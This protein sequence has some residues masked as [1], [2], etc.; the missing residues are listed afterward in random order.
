M[1]T[2][3]DIARWQWPGATVVASTFD[4]WWAAFQDAVPLLPV[5]TL[6][7]GETWIIGFA[8]DPYKAAFYR[9][10][11]REYD[12]CVAGGGCAAGDARLTAFLRMMIKFTEHTFGLPTINDN[13]NYTNAQFEAARAAG[14][15]TYRQ[16]ESSWEEQRQVGTVYAMEALGDHPLAAAINA[17]L[18]AIAPALPNPLAAGY[19]SWPYEDIAGPIV[20]SLPGGGEV[21]VG[22]DPVTSSLIHLSFNG[23]ASVVDRTNVMGQFVYHTM[24]D[25]DIDTQ[26]ITVDGG[27]HACC[28]CY[29]CAPHSPSPHGFVLGTLVRS[30]M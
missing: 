28:C 1:L 29:G 11:A 8:S 22:F 9:T 23:S 3:F 30:L 24:N 5:T 15:L 13:A 26:H 21:A 10:V 25:T 12:A 18:P 20:V 27:Q 2:Q 17:A 7:M 6:E 19:S 14:V 4:E 16:V